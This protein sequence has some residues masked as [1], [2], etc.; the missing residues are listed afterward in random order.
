LELF[1]LLEV[2]VVEAGPLVAAVCSEPTPRLGT[3]E[4][5]RTIAR[6]PTVRMSERLLDLWFSMTT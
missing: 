1:A 6:C 2:G 4:R 5:E 3:L